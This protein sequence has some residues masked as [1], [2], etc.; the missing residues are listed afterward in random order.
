MSDLEVHCTAA[1]RHRW[2]DDTA[3]D[4]TPKWWC[5]KCGTYTTRNPRRDAGQKRTPEQ[6]FWSKVDRSGGPESCWIWTASK[7]KGYGQFS[8]GRQFHYAHRW[9]Y[10]QA[11]GPIP[12][13]YQLDHLCRTPACVNPRHL[14]AVT[15]RENTMRSTSFVVDQ[16]K[17]T[18]CPHGH[19]YTPENTRITKKGGRQCRIC[20]NRKG[21]IR[22]VVKR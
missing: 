7:L 12:D 19:E 9:S 6:R 11:V 14:E 3:P 2:W 20:D 17:R 13:G 8:I 15:P 21:R 10:E 18:H 22:T 5:S 4:G 1:L 16:T